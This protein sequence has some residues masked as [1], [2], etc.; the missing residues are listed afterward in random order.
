MDGQLARRDKKFAPLLDQFVCVRLVECY[1]LDRSLFQFDSS[2]TMVSFFMNADGQVY[3]RYGSRAGRDDAE[4]VSAEG[5]RAAMQGA[6]ALH[7]L[8]QQDRK[9][10]E[11]KL[12]GK[13][14]KESPW[15]RYED[16]PLMKGRVM[17]AIR[18]NHKCYH[19]HWVQGGEILSRR[20]EGR[21]IPDQW[22]WMY[23]VPDLLGMRLDPQTRATVASVERGSAADKAGIQKGDEILELDSQ[24][25][26]SLADVQWVLHRADDG[27]RLPV[28][29]HRSGG[30]Q[31]LQLELPQGWRRRGDISWRPIEWML[32]GE[33]LGFHMKRM[34]DR[35]KRR[36]HV[37]V[38]GPAYWIERVAPA[39]NKNANHAARKAG[40][41]KGDILIAID[42]QPLPATMSLFLAWIAQET[43]PGQKIRITVLRQGRRQEFSYALK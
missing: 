42:D 25:I 18:D 1:G 41:K 12:V 17:P 11:A 4:L 33:V 23:P 24:P 35:E 9:A 15:S 31:T 32:R 13:T 7:R 3:G 37:D 27:R 28:L 29:V 39:W 20:K 6:L 40:L 19:C 10:V 8:W 14:A 30:K 38:D 22:L 43:R 21:E 5:L 26:L 36:H 16:I 34:N 2:L